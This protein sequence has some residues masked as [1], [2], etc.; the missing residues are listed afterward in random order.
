MWAWLK[1]LWARIKAFFSFKPSEPIIIKPVKYDIDFKSVFSSL[2]K[3]LESERSHLL[4]SSTI[5]FPIIIKDAASAPVPNNEPKFF[6]ALYQKNPHFFNYSTHDFD[7]SNFNFSKK[8][9]YQNYQQAAI[10]DYLSHH[11]GA[12]HS[13]VLNDA[14][15]H[16]QQEQCILITLTRT[17]NGFSQT[18]YFL[19]ASHISSTNWIEHINDEIFQQS[20]AI[21]FEVIEKEPFTYA[22]QQALYDMA[23]NFY[24]MDIQ[25][26]QML[27]GFE[28]ELAKRFFLNNPESKNIFAL[29]DREKTIAHFNFLKNTPMY[30]D[31]ALLALREMY[32]ARKV[33]SYRN[34][35]MVS[36]LE[37]LFKNHHQIIAA[38][39]LTHL[40]QMIHQLQKNG[41]N[42][43]QELHY[44][45]KDCNLAL[46]R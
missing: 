9:A 44:K 3:K 21:A 7:F 14:F 1:R 25:Q 31:E 40:P 12:Y 39:G 13:D 20:E 30:S 26:D 33:D 34:D 10:E 4:D 46:C 8:Q 6:S 42:I 24:Q 27:Y 18:L 43:S 38:V 11:Q 32:G 28:D 45:H 29:E 35:T 36:S 16:W 2:E 5:N 22:S 37:N 17:T 15:K 19:G 23:T 41:F